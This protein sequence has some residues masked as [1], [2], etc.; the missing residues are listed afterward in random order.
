MNRGTGTFETLFGIEIHLLGLRYL[1]QDF[2]DDN[3][4]VYTDITIPIN[5]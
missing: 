4:V 5:N 1:L 2:L 3:T